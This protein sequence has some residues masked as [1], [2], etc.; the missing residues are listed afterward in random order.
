MIIISN[1][2][3]MNTIHRASLS[4]IG[5]FTMEEKAHKQITKKTKRL[6]NK[7]TFQYSLRVARPFGVQVH[8]NL[9]MV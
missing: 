9:K 6:R 7:I 2:I 1:N 8:K 5:C 4:T 3:Q